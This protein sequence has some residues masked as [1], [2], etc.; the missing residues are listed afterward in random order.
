M[1]KIIGWI[2]LG[3]LLFVFLLLFLPVHTRVR[4]DGAVQVW[5]GLGPVSLRL[6]PLKKKAERP[7]KEKTQAAETKSQPKKRSQRDRSSHGTRSAIIF[8]LPWKRWALCAGDW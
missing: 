7:K 4:Y 8:G 1:L 6:F 3:F 2:F 5:C